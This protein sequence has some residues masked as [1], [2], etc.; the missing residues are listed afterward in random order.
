MI[1]MYVHK[2]KG[3][4]KHRRPTTGCC[5]KMKERR[6]NGKFQN[7]VNKDKIAISFK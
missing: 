7:E 4:Q 2:N 1:Y 5:R 3:E 6:I